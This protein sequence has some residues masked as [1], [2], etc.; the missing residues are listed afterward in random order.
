MWMT[1]VKNPGP[2]QDAGSELSSSL[3]FE[4]ELELLRILD[5]PTEQRAKAIE[6]FER[7]QPDHIQALREILQTATW[8]KAFEELP[9]PSLPP[10]GD[11]LARISHE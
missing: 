11:R 1:M 7:D 3:P 10:V 5:L 8:A 6:E 2:D 4:T 9:R